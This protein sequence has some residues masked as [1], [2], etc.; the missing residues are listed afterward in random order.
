MSYW[1]ALTP[2]AFVRKGRTRPFRV[3]CERFNEETFAFETGDWLVKAPRE[4]VV[5]PDEFFREI[6][7]LRLARHFSLSTARVAI[8]DLDA[9]F[10][11]GL[12][13]TAFAKPGFLAGI[14]VGC[15]TTRGIVTLSETMPL[16]RIGEAAARLL[17]AFDLLFANDDRSVSNPNCGMVKGRLFTYDFERILTGPQQPAWQVSDHDFGPRH[18]LHRHLQG[19]SGGWEPFIERLMGL[20]TA[21]LRGQADDLPPTLE[22]TRAFEQTP[23][24]RCG[25]PERTS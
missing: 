24:S 21:F 15:E 23:A 9:E 7:G 14:G 19:T 8:I 18:I 12:S 6:V 22:H 16:Q 10:I 4:G 25:S 3:I 17:Y 13:G 5:G 20:D 11:E 1:D 2:I